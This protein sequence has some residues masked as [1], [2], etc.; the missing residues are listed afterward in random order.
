[1]D[2]DKQVSLNPGFVFSLALIVIPSFAWMLDYDFSSTDNLPVVFIAIMKIGAFGGM[3][4]FAWSLI[5]SGRYKIFDSLFGGLDKVYVAHRFFGT[6]SIALLLL[7]PLG[8]T[9]L[10]LYREGASDLINH[11]FGYKSMAFTLGRLSL[12]GLILAGLWSIFTKVKH[13]IFVLIHRWLGLFF[14]FGALHAFLS[15]SSSTSVFAGNGFMYWYMAALTTM[16]I[17][18]FFHYSLLGDFLHRHY[19]YKVASVR[20]LPGDVWELRLKPKY[21]SMNFRPGQFAYLSFAT[22]TEKSHH[23]FTIA[24]GNR[25]SELIFYIKELGDL[26]DKLGDLKPGAQVKVKGPYGGFT[27]DNKKF[28]KQLW[29]AAGIG[30][31][32]FLSRARSLAYAKHTQEVEMLYMVGKKSESFAYKELFELEKKSSSFNVTLVEKSKFGHKS[33]HDI[34][35]HFGGLEDYAIYLCG[36]PGMIKAYSEQVHELGLEH[37]LH[38]EE[39][40]Y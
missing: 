12:Y 17:A 19:S 11:F 10:Y 20:P 24:S 14:M 25:S 28:N 6:A 15:S 32:P 31:T 40:D 23:P 13:E 7:H 22:L 33:L 34:A 4:M 35:E 5:L 16:A 9:F 27:F 30:V 38:F 1:M 2:T 29:L 37:Q 36:P 18:S 21:R 26:T 3:A 39:F 8:Y